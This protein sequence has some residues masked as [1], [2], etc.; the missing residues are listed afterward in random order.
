MQ[1][2][3]IVEI[4]HKSEPMWLHWTIIGNVIAS[5]EQE[6]N[7]LLL[8]IPWIVIAIRFWIDKM[9]FLNWLGEFL[10]WFPILHPYVVIRHELDTHQQKWLLF[11]VVMRVR[12]L[13]AYLWTQIFDVHK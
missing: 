2:K 13:R 4:F 11:D 3:I 9:Q 1:R 6:K 8:S 5:I 7:K 12:T 10:S